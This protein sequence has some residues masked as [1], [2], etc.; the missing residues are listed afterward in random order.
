MIIKKTER[1]YR[2][3]KKKWPFRNWENE[4]VSQTVKRTTIWIMFIPIIHWERITQIN[5]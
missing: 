3:T 1:I 4:K 2:T 5:I